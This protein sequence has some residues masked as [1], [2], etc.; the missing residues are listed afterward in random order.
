MP[1]YNANTKHFDSYKNYKFR[2]R[3]DSKYVAG[4]S[5][6]SELK[7]TTQKVE[8]RTVGDSSFSGKSPSRTQ[9]EAITLERA[10]LMIWSLRTGLTKCGNM[11]LD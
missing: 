6:M 9:Y 2:I 1:E 5:K 7:R 11:V 3:F 8:L 10:L 4:L